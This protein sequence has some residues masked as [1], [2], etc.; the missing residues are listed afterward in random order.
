MRK[1]QRLACAGAILMVGVLLGAFAGFPA[2]ALRWER[3][4][5][6]YEDRVVVTRA[7]YDSDDNELR[8]RADSSSGTSVL[9]V[10]D[11]VGALI[12]VLA[13]QDATRH[14]GRFDLASNPQVITVRSSEGGQAT[15]LVIGD[16]PPT[17]TPES[18]PT[19]TPTVEATEPTPS[20]TPDESPT[21]TAT[22][23]AT[24]PTPSVT[25]EASP[26]DGPTTPPP[27]LT[28]ATEPQPQIY[29]PLLLDRTPLLGGD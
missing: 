16:D 10:Y 28:Q 6:A 14:E 9:S 1:S 20:A 17:V 22:P 12:G 15:V 24:E 4:S 29:L 27:T 8:I 2:E 11:R 7:E 23:E 25:P 19:A 5:D 21:S 3:F 26:T 18:L 13:R